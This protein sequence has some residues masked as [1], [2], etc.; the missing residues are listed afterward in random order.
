MPDNEAM[1]DMCKLNAEACKPPLPL[2][3]VARIYAS[4]KGKH[5]A[6]KDQD[7]NLNKK[8]VST[9]CHVGDSNLW[10]DMDTMHARKTDS[11]NIKHMKMFPG[12]KDNNPKIATWLPL[13]HGFLDVDTVTWIPKPYGTIHKVI[14]EGGIDK[15]N[16]WNGFAITPAEGDIDPWLT[17]LSHVVPEEDYRE[18]FLFW[19]AFTI[20]HPDIKLQW[21][22]II[23]GMSG[24]GKDTLLNPMARIFGDAYR[25]SG[26]KDTKGNFDDTLFKTKLLQISEA[27]GMRGEHIEFFKRIAAS[28]AS[29]K[30]TLNIKQSGQVVQPNLFSIVAMTNDIAAFKFDVNE[31]RALV[32]NA[33]KKMDDKDADAY[34]GGWL[35]NNGANHLFHYLLNYDLDASPYSH[36]KLPYRTT[37]FYN[38]ND[39]SRSDSDVF[40]D[41][42][43]TDYEAILPQLLVEKLILTKGNNNVSAATKHLLS[44]GWARWDAGDN[45]RRIKKSVDGKQKS[46]PRG[47]L[48]RKD[49]SLTNSRPSVMYDACQ[50]SRTMMTKQSKFG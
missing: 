24:A 8:L 35:K 29:D 34:Y 45:S 22:I 20:Q 7:A 46:E 33:P 12:G 28:E 47:W 14:T 3:D 32:L 17:L 10:Y 39:V 15:L 44:T 41:E 9:L 19:L 38:M 13:Q 6:K 42:Y 27:S 40:V 2:E 50:A 37:H 26:N 49:G 43:I 23:I 4:I 5:Q 21:Q 31:R 11:L 25:S 30:M 36:S 48:I 1:A 16:L 18:A